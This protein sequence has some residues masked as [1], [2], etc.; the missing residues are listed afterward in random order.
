MTL[1]ELQQLANGLYGDG[2]EVQEYFDEKTGRFKEAKDGDLLAA[3]IAAELSDT[4]DEEDDIL[5]LK[6]GLRV[7]EWGIRDLEEV[8]RGFMRKIDEVHAQ[9]KKEEQSG[10]GSIL[11]EGRTAG[12]GGDGGGHDLPGEGEGDVGGGPV[13]AGAGAQG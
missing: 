10:S 2:W 13:D 4:F 3:F 6:E 7:I 12:V 1:L 9:R 5:A 8:A 11:P